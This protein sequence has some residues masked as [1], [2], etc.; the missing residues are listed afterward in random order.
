MKKKM[1]KIDRLYHK[2]SGVIGDAIIYD[3]GYRMDKKSE[4]KCD[5]IQEQIE[6]L[7]DEIKQGGN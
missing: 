6:K 3:D 4:E 5:K 2:M 7:W 1:E